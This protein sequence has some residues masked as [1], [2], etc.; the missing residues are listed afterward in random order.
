M[1]LMSDGLQKV[2]GDRLRAFLEAV[3]N[4]RLVGCVVGALVTAVVQSSSV[5]T[6]TMV[7]FVNAGLMNLTQAV[8]VI[9]G[10]NVGTTITAQLIAFKISDIALPAIFVGVAISFFAK[11]RKWRYVGEIILGFGLLFYGMELMKN[12]FKPLRTHPDFISFFTKFDANS[13]GGILLCVLTGTVLTVLV[14]SSSATVGITMA[15]ASQGLLN[16]PGSVALILGDNIGTTV[17][18][19]LA[20]IGSNIHARRVAMAHTIFNVFGVLYIVVLF[21][22]FVGLVSWITSSVMGA[23]GAEAVVAGEKPNISRYIANAHTLFN[24]VNCVV[25]LFLMPILVKASIK[26]TFGKEPDTVLQDMGRPI[27]L[28]YKFVDNPSVALTMAREETV[29]MGRLAQVMYRDVTEVMFN[30]KLENLARWKQSEEALDNLQKAITDFLVQVSQG[31]ITD[32]ES[33]EINSLLRMVNNI[34]RVGDATEN[35]A[36]LTEEMVENK[37]EL[38]ER[39]ME[40]YRTMRNKVGRFLEMVVT[41][42]SERNRDIMEVAQTMEDEIDFM[43]EE[44]RDDYLTRLR[45]GVCTVDPG[46]VFVDMLTNFEKVGDYCYNVA[47][48]VA[49]LR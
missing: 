40:D 38:A 4:K 39:G 14:Q 6:V 17:T 24:V 41:A 26:L 32:T 5:T 7:G 45:S 36:E 31:S 28:D 34:E 43:R 10:A 11:R 3:S 18:A 48:A 12:G 21:N 8:G 23:G 1:K 27:H 35:L 37:L 19:Q 22:P 42:T 29:R 46:L 2:A 15:L 44:M 30:R 47:Q 49:G 13:T 16:L 33:R 25:F 9:L 20:A